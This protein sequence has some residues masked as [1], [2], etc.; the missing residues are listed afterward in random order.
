MD[1]PLGQPLGNGPA[2]Q[3]FSNVI[4]KLAFFGVTSAH[5]ILSLQ[6][7]TNIITLSFF[8]FLQ[9]FTPDP[10]ETITPVVLLYLLYERSLVL[11]ITEVQAHRTL[12]VVTLGQ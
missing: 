3:M 1:R 2:A 11:S 12:F 6:N 7:L 10:V 4:Y 5:T 9:Y 8:F